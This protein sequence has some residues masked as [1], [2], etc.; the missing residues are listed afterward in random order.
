MRKNKKAGILIENVM[1][2]ILNLVFLSLLMA[3]LLMQGS[4]IIVLEQS[5]AKQIALMIDSARP[6]ETIFLNM[7]DA[8]KKAEKNL[9][10]NRIVQI[11]DNIVT[12]KLSEKS[13]Y[14]YSFFNTPPNSYYAVSIQDAEHLTSKGYF[15]NFLKNEKSSN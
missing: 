1:F 11:K 8:F 9:G 3:F 12:V 14:S 13:G 6:G 4:G 10:D 15:F 2:I 5:Y 7:D